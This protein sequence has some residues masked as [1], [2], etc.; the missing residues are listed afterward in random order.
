VSSQAQADLWVA[1]DGN[2]PIS[3]FFAIQASAG[4]QSGYFGYAFD[5]THL[6]D[7]AANTLPTP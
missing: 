2:Y 1:K 6:N 3:G 7:T 4:G 5:V